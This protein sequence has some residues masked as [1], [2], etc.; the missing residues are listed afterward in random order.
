MKPFVF[1]HLKLRMEETKFAIF[2]A[3]GAEEKWD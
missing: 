3:D 1:L 2:M